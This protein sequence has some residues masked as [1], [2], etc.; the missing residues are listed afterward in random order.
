MVS[1]E[2]LRVMLFV[3]MLSALGIELWVEVK[4]VLLLDKTVLEVLQ[5]FPPFHPVYEVS[6]D[7]PVVA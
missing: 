2:V 7:G 5:V 4:M 3:D 6:L 1:V